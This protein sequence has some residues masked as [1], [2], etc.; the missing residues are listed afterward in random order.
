MQFNIRK[1]NEN[2]YDDILV[3]WWNDWGWTPPQADFLPDNG[4]GGIMVLDG[5]E[6]ICAG[7]LY[8]TN[9]KVAWVDWIV[10]SKTYR[11][12]PNRKDAIMELVNQLT[13]IAKMSGFTYTYALIKNRSL[14]EIYSDLGY[15]EGDSYTSEMIKR[16]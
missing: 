13:N 4:M 3:G 9:S 8:A 14:I 1:L 11:K 15:V 10:S 12:K 5:D 6:P 2:D 16:N 7:Y